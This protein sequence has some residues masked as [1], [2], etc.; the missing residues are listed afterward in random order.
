MK[1]KD[2]RSVIQPQFADLLYTGYYC[3]H[4]VFEGIGRRR[5]CEE[6]GFMVAVIPK[7]HEQIHRHINTGEALKYKQQCQKWYESN[8]GTR[9]KF[10][11]EFGKNYLMGE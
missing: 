1:K 2:C 9:E 4:H 7:V 5:K 10:I 6:Y 8:I 11:L 3:I